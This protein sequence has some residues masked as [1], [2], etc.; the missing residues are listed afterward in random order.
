VQIG[1]TIEGASGLQYALSEHARQIPYANTLALNATG[2]SVKRAVEL[3]MR[4]N[5]DRPNPRVMK[6]IFLDYATKTALV[7]EV[8]V[9]DIP[10]N[11]ADESLAEIIGQ[12]FTGG[13]GRLRGRL[14]QAFT[15]EG[16]IS[17]GEYLIPGSGARLD[18][19][20]NLSKGQIN[21]I[22]AALRL[23]HDPYQNATQSSRSK[24]NARKAGYLFWSHGKGH[25][26]GMRRGLWATD[27]QGGPALVLFPVPGVSYKQRIDMAA[28]AGRVVPQVWD[29]NFRIAWNYAVRTAK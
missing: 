21:Q 22:Y 25:S 18:R 27:A 20:G 19:Y 12:Q 23:F 1:V 9:K 3:D 28:I 6:G 15:R 2:R 29:R 26:S 10:E 5:F 14:E 13:V 4:A 24:A 11:F 8:R 17:A 7:A 16:Y